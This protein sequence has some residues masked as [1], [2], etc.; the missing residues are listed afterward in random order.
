[1]GRKFVNNVIDEIGIGPYQ[2]IVLVFAGGVYSAEGAVLLIAGLVANGVIFDWNLTPLHAGAMAFTLFMGIAIGTMIGALIADQYGRLHPIFCTYGGICV[3]LLCMCISAGYAEIIISKFL[4][5]LFLGFGL[6]G[7]NVMICECCPMDQ[8]SNIYSMSMVMFAL[9][10]MYSAAI[11]WGIAPTLQADTVNWRLLLFFG[12]IPSGLLL[13]CSYFFLKE[14]PHF[15][16]TEGRYDECEKVLKYM[17]KINGKNEEEILSEARMIEIR[18]ETPRHNE[19]VSAKSEEEEGTGWR[20]WY[21]R[22]S[23][24][25]STSLWRCKS[26]FNPYYRTTTIIVGFICFSSN[27]TYYGMVYGVPRTLQTL[28]AKVPGGDKHEGDGWSAAGGVFIATL[29]EIPGVFISILFGATLSRK[30][31]MTF[32]F[33]T[34]SIL[35]VVIGASNWTEVESAGFWLV[36]VVKMF[37]AAGFI[38]IYLYMLE[39][40]PTIFRATG[41]AYN[42]VIGRIGAF[43]CPFVYELL[44]QQTESF[45]PFFVVLGVFLGAA[46]ILVYF[47]PYETKGK[48]LVEDEPLTERKDWQR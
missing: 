44:F 9:G 7:A 23:N 34:A 26:L 47:L 25:I 10:Q 18:Q 39:C 19:T 3:F 28:S 32:I 4:L 37:I 41:L 45:L 2:M 35:L 48:S 46:G 31:T 42:M 16:F 24:G 12:M 20:V 5:G 40:Y 1:M 22:I 29:F 17:A 14:S 36:S 43:L 15:L 30:S 27:L 11:I 8:R 21:N 13:I 38:I 6:P 33:I